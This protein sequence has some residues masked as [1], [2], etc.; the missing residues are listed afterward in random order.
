MMGMPA[1]A[2]TPQGSFWNMLPRMTGPPFGILMAP[3][4]V[5]PAP[6]LPPNPPLRRVQ[7]PLTVLLLAPPATA[8][9][10]PEGGAA[11]R[12][13]DGPAHRQSRAF[14]SDEPP[15]AQGEAVDHRI[16][17]CPLGH[18]DDAG[19]SH[20]W[21]QHCVGWPQRALAAFGFRAC[22]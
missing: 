16:A 14:A 7:P 12:K 10:H 3:R 19:A 5:S 15:V 8:R 2:S 9:S 20:R 11:V 1:R 13:F 4:T 6:S 18:G 21:L 17:A 22:E